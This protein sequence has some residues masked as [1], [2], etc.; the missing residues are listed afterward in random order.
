MT[1]QYESA[2]I[3]D[4]ANV[5]MWSPMMDGVIV[6]TEKGRVIIH[7]SKICPLLRSRT[8]KE[9]EEDKEEERKAK[10]LRSFI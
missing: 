9:E 8:K 2:G 7:K 10:A 1:M 3:N 5:A 4:N 6:G